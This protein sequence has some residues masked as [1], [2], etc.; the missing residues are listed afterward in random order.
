MIDN[1]DYIDNIDYID[2][3]DYID[4]ISRVLRILISDDSLICMCLSDLWLPFIIG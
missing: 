4:K 1:K 3:I 2:I